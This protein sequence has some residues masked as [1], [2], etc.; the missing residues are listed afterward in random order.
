MEQ[1][2]F[3]TQEPERWFWFDPPFHNGQSALLHKQ[4]DN[5]Y[6]I[7]LQLR[8]DTD[9]EAEA[10]EKEHV[11][12]RIKAVVGDTPFTLDWMSIYQFRCAMLDRFVHNRVIF[13][14]DSAHVVSPFGARGG[15]GGIQDVDNL[16]W[17][18]VAVLEGQDIGDAA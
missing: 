11:L 13:V 16:A 8:P 17:K 18:L 5:I 9:L 12:P 2:P 1:S 6:R 10:R 14:G 4:P 3:E 7:D 15:N